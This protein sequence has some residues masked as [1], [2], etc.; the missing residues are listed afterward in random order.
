MGLFEGPRYS[1]VSEAP[2]DGTP[3]LQ[4]AFVML[5]ARSGDVLAW[6]GGR[7]YSHS[8]F[9]RVAQARRQPGSAFKPFVYAAALS[10]GWVLSQPLLDQP[11]QVRLPNG[12]IWKPR[13]FTGRYEGRITM[14]DALVRSKNVAT[15]RLASAVGL[16]EVADLALRRGDR[17]AG[18]AGALA[19]A[20]VGHR[21][22]PGADVRLYRLRHPGHGRGAPPHPESGG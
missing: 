6:V 17:R 15:V 11:L 8:Q 5:D 12:Q 1:L 21:L 9:D 13:N 14:R 10:Q 7:D 19:G 4:G 22:A 16:D 18:L 20:G 3:Y 2:E